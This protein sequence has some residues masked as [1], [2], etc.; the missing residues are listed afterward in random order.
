MQCVGAAEGDVCLFAADRTPL[1]RRVLGELRNNLGRRL[2]LI[3]KGRWNFLWVTSFPMFE[4]DAELE[5]WVALHHPFTAP[6]DWSMGGPGA[7]P[8]AL[9]SRAYDLVLNGWELGSGSIRIHQSDVQQRVFDLLGIGPEEQQRKFGFLLEALA[10]GAPPHGGFALGLDRTVALTL[11]LDNL[12][13]QLPFPKTT[14]AT[15]LMC[16]APSEVDPR[17]LAE[18]HVR[19]TAPPPAAP[20]LGG[21][22]A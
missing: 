19:S 10:H 8:G 13:D 17:Q 2:G 18:V 6:R 3:E 5:R 12:R 21:A 16:Q 11:G 7:D 22:G 1:A 15:D 20:A 9:D 14:S 4:R